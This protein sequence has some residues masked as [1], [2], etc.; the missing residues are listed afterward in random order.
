MRKLIAL[1]GLLFMAAPLF[2]AGPSQVATLDRSVWPDPIDSPAAF[3][4][5]S[6]AELLAFGRALSESEQL[7][8]DALR[9]RLKLKSLDRGSVEHM[10]SVYWHRLAANYALAASHCTPA[11]P[12]CAAGSGESALREAAAH[13]SVAAED[14]YGAWFQAAQRFHRNYLSELLRLAALFPKTSSEVQTY[15]PRELSGNEL[16]DRE[17][18]LTFD[19]GPTAANGNTDAMLAILRQQRV[20]A[21]FFLLG[22]RLQSRLQQTPEAQLAANYRG[23]CTGA[24]GWEHKSH[25]TWPEWQNS[26]ELSIGLVRSQLPDSFVPLFRPPYG[27]R[28]ADSGKFFDDHVLRVTLW[29]IDSQDWNAKVDAD[30]VKQRVMTLMLLWRHGVILFHD[31]HAKAQTAVPWLVDQTRTSGVHWIDCHAFPPTGR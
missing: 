31:I 29:N 9:D 1:F 14:R 3:D 8:D 19:D 12:F 28:E 21:T 22:E 24:H 6:R 11:E 7:D 10:R 25:S 5:A 23:M 4:R 17:F 26:I 15:S 20:N 18:L 13:L 30:H 2:A 16:A 27:Q